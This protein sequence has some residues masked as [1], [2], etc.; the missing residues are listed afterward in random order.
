MKK[1]LLLLILACCS[2]T[3]PAQ[4]ITTQGTEFWVSF[5][6]NGFKDHPNYGLWLRIQLLVSAKNA[7][8]GTLT[9]PQTG[10]TQSFEVGANSTLLLDDINQD[11]AYME[12][13]E[14]ETVRN[15]GLL[16]TTTDTVSV[17]CTNLAAY[18]FDASYVMPTQGLSDS[19]LIQTFDQSTEDDTHTSAF[20]IVATEDNTTIDITPT[21]K[22]LGNK[23]AGQEFSITLNRGQAYQV[24]SHNGWSGSRDL[25]GTRVIA[26]DCKKIAVFNGNN[27]T[28]VPTSGNDSDC[29]F[30]Q[31][32]PLK[33]WGKKFVATASLGRQLD[34]VVKVISANDNNEIRINGTLWATL[35]AGES[36]TFNLHIAEKSCFIEASQ[37][38][39]VY[40]YNHSKEGSIPG[41]GYGAP[42]MVWIAPIEQRIDD[43][44][45]STFNC[46][47]SVYRNIRQVCQCLLVDA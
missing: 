8:S 13:S 25:S 28:K 36:K 23:P 14:Y 1:I 46:H 24:R 34:D 16:I 44:T 12:M 41:S 40:L 11:Q 19:Y 21:V 7:C 20:L 43:I 39:A 22:T 42:S 6:G 3:L 31:A 45:F 4:D 2:L 32:M 29:I 5:M 18:S 30:E 9:N 38:C 10:W 35:N 37:R 26:R 33:A 15:K 27:L 17:Y 47:E